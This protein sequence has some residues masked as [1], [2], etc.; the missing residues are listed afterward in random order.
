MRIYPSPVVMDEQKPPLQPCFADGTGMPKW[1]RFRICEVPKNAHFF[2]TMVLLMPSGPIRFS[3][4]LMLQDCCAV[5]AMRGELQKRSIHHS[6]TR[7]VSG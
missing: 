4:W 3:L 5:M 7:N 1:E 2:H 6:V